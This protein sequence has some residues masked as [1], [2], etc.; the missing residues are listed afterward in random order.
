MA[1]RAWG[2]AAWTAAAALLAALPGGSGR[3]GD[4]R[5]ASFDCGNASSPSEKTICVNQRLSLIDDDIARAYAQRLAR[6]PGVRQIQRG[7]LR[8]RDQGCAE[9]AACLRNMM[10]SQLDWLRG[11][12][13][14]LP[15]SL[16]TREGD[17]GVSTVKRVGTRLDTPG[18]GSAIEEVD[19]AVQVSYDTIPAIDRSRRGDPTLVC[20][21]QLPS[22]C[23]PGDDRGKV[24]AVAN[25]RTLGAWSAPDAEHLCGGA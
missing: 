17:C 9:D 23:P 25:L 4:V 16:P 13:V 10:I 6:D 22:D 11:R 3:N 18:S 14:N 1:T 24:Y 5:A 20:L 7:W 15:A 12:D 19:G 8:A 2:W 21:V